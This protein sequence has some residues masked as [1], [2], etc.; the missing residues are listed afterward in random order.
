M[1]RT[2]LSSPKVPGW[3]GRALAPLHH[4]QLVLE[5]HQGD[6]IASACHTFITLRGLAQCLTLSVSQVEAAPPGE[7]P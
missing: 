1:P 7:R 4:F 5:H 6:W 2:P 3:G